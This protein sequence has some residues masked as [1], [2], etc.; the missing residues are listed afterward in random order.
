LDV[1]PGL[2]DI[3]EGARSNL[4]ALQRCPHHAPRWAAG[5]WSPPPPRR[6]PYL[7]MLSDLCLKRNFMLA[8]LTCRLP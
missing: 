3:P 5:M 7:A 1:V 8:T 2:I 4:Q 6:C